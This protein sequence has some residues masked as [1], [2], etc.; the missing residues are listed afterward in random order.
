MSYIYHGTTG[1]VALPNRSVQTY[2]SGL[3][4][5]ERSFVCRK[6]LASKYRSI[7]GVNQ[8]MPNDDGSPAIDGIYIF[9]EPQETMRDGGFIEFKVTAYGRHNLSPEFYENKLIVNSFY[10][11]REVRDLRPPSPIF[12]K[13]DSLYQSTLPAISE[14][15]VYRHV[16]PNDKSVSDILQTPAITRPTII[17]ASGLLE[18]KTLTP[19]KIQIQTI[20]GGLLMS[21]TR[22]VT[23]SFA[24]S[25]FS[26]ANFGIWSEWT[27]TY[28][29][30]AVV[31][32]NLVIPNP[33]NE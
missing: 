4:R 5:V 31:I 21:G 24:L 27:Y 30:R 12:A 14:A 2:P 7:L 20:L 13:A 3:V 26:S 19:G 25:Q 17:D 9:P 28:E 32:D 33:E 18:F 1:L 23:I 16:L 11:Q 8:P 6:N 22:E 29:T 15:Y 10:Y